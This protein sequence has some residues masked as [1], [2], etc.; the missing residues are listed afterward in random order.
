MRW[1]LGTPSKLVLSVLALVAGLVLMAEIRDRIEQI[2]QVEEPERLG[3]TRRAVRWTYRLVEIP[4]LMPQV[5]DKDL[6]R[7]RRLTGR[8]DLSSVTPDQIPSAQPIVVADV[9]VPC[10]ESVESVEI[11][12]V[13]E[14]SG[15]VTHTAVPSMRG[16]FGAPMDWRLYAEVDSRDLG[17]FERL[18]YELGAYL[19]SF[20]VNRWLVAPKIGFEQESLPDGETD[21]AIVAGFRAEFDI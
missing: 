8:P 18:E 14:P 7:L 16:F 3:P 1:T 17:S 20:R 9:M 12:A 6:Q 2:A 5:Q 4:V 15:E 13:R 19:R 11:V 21:S 10:D